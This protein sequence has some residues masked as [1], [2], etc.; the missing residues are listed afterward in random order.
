MKPSL[1]I[2]N[3]VKFETGNGGLPRVAVTGPLAN[4]TI[5]RYGAHV[6]HFQPHGEKPVLFMTRQAQ[7]IPGKP[8]RG[9]IP[10]VFPW[11]GPHPTDTNLPMHGPSR[12][13]EWNL[14]STELRADGAVELVFALPPFLQY[15][16]AIGR[17]LDLTLEVYN[18]GQT[19]FKFE[20]ALHTYFCVSDVRQIT[21]TGL[22]NT[23]YDSKVENVTGQLQGSD[24]IRFTG[25]VDRTY[26]N[27]NTTCIIH[28]PTW[29]RRIVVEKRNSDT[30]QLWNPWI[31]RAKAIPDFG[32]D[33]WPGM[34]CIE[35]VN[36]RVN[37]VTLA[38]GQTHAMRTIARVEKI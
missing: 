25:E 38:P 32:D 8:I 23:R 27:T 11:F 28:D 5:Y 12:L 13:V 15:R 37:A 10:I 26:L 21:V 29:Q 36:A 35:T 24:P 30:T 31:A 2:P 20:E 17:E 14:V 19:P 16:V 9:G 4:A 7:F 33:E 3:V 6:T 22:E 1:E 34:V 18:S